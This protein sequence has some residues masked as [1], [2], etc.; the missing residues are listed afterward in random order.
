MEDFFMNRLNKFVKSFLVASLSL[1]FLMPNAAITS[2]AAVQVGEQVSKYDVTGTYRESNY[3]IETGTNSYIF[4]T[5]SS[6]DT[7][8]VSVKSSSS[9]LK[10]FKRKSTTKIASTYSNSKQTNVSTSR[11]SV[12]VYGYAKKAGTYTIKYDIKDIN[13]VKQ[14]PTQTVTVVAK[15]DI[16][17]FKKITYAGKSIWDNEGSRF[18]DV[19]ESVYTNK[20]K[21]KLVVKAASGYKIKKIEVGTLNAVTSTTESHSTYDRVTTTH[22]DTSIVYDDNGNTYSMY[23]EYGNATTGIVTYKKVKSGKKISIGTT[24]YTEE[25]VDS[26]DGLTITHSQIYAPTAIRVTYYDKT[27]KKTFQWSTTIFYVN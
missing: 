26:D 14:Y 4:A 2:N 17:P 24:P 21:G 8:K 13:G 27:T 22:K 9:N 12:A 10:I 23:D 19:T 18:S 25:S 6:T 3:L 1:A 5:P 11:T 20:K 7:Y 15:D 16:S